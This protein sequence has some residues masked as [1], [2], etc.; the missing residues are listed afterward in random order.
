MK[1]IDR[2]K[3]HDELNSQFGHNS[4]MIAFTDRIIDSCEKW[5]RNNNVSRMD[6]K[7]A[8]DTL[9]DIIMQEEMSYRGGGVLSL[10]PDWLLRWILGKIISYIIMWWLENRK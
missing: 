2:T 9:K 1:M 3:L 7:E 4:I 8:H 10:I 5:A 6:R